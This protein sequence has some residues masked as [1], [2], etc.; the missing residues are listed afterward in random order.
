M[1]LCFC[2]CEREEKGTGILEERDRACYWLLLLPLVTALCIDSNASP[3][4][5]SCHCNEFGPLALFLLI[6]CRM[7]KT[8]LSANPIHFQSEA[9]MGILTAVGFI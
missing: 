3:E 6:L 4:I 2:M 1:S 9:S 7:N 8:S 5:K